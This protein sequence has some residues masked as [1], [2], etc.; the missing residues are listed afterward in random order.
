EGLAIANAIKSSK[1]NVHTYV[2]GIAYS[3]AAIITLAAPLGKAHMAKGS[4]LMLHSASTYAYGNAEELR[5]TADVLDKY[6]NA[7]V[8]FVTDRT[9]QTLI[10]AKAAY[11]NHSDNFYTPAEALALT[12]IDKVEDY[13]AS[14]TPDNVR[15]MNIGQVAAW[16]MAST[17]EPTESF[18]SKVISKVRNVINPEK[19]ENMFNKFSKLSALAKVAANDISKEVLEE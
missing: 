18:I 1:K 17:D 10:E 13:Q 14:E 11:F 8:S 16:Y 7:L 6:D 2:D 19:S 5:E 4:L 9:G 12:L 3:M 15:N